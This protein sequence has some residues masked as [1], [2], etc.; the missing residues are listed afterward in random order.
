MVRNYG[1]FLDLKCME[2]AH[3]EFGGIASGYIYDVYLNQSNWE[4]DR[5]KIYVQLQV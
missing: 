4:S 3:I 2:Y 1:R 5:S